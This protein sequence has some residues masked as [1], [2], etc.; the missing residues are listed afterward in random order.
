MRLSGGVGHNSRYETLQGKVNH[1]ARLNLKDQ[2]IDICACEECIYRRQL[3]RKSKVHLDMSKDSS[4][5]R[6]YKQKS[7][8]QTIANAKV[9]VDHSV[10]NRDRRSTSSVV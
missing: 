10:I 6:A 4:Y 9:S 5:R 1:I 3:N 8:T 2:D 7:G